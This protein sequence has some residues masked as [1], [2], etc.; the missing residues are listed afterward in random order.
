MVNF[1]EASRQIRTQKKHNTSQK[2]SKKKT[3][4]LHETNRR[5]GY[6]ILKQRSKDIKETATI[7]GNLD[8]NIFL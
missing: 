4:L 1:K 5:K 7:Q 6:K 8:E 3:D 2:R